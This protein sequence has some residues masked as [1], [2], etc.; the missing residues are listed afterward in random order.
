MVEYQTSKICFIG[1]YRVAAMEDA[2]FTDV[3]FITNDKGDLNWLNTT[4]INKF[5][6][7]ANGVDLCVVALGIN[8][9]SNLDGYVQSLNTFAEKYH[10]KV[11]IYANIGPVD[12]QKQNTLT[13]A[14]LEEFNNKIIYGLSDQW[15]I[16]NQYEYIAASGFDSED[17]KTYSIY[18]SAKIFA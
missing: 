5:E 13:N 8:D 14:Q 9:I 10:D 1:D 11:F 4:A 18:D 3:Q 2:V 17:G 16:V 15:K 7:I 6:S 12:E